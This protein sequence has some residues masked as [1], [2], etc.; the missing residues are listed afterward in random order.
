MYVPSA[1]LFFIFSA[2]RLDFLG[3]NLTSLS[4]MRNFVVVRQI[5]RVSTMQAL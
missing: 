5:P 4:F 2:A 1:S 3:L